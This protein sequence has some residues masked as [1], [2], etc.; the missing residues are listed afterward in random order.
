M[1]PAQHTHYLVLPV[2]PALTEYDAPAACLSLMSRGKY[3]L[4]QGSGHADR[5]ALA[6]ALGDGML[7]D[8][9]RD[10]TR[11]IRVN[12]FAAGYVIEEL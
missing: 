12:D 6:D 7:A 11:P 5:R 1:E 4:V 8:L 3:V 10:F 9:L 2:L